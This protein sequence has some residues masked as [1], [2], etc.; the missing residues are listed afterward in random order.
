MV[1]IG[2]TTHSRL[3]P[4]LSTGVAVATRLKDT[5]D[6][7]LH[8]QFVDVLR[9]WSVAGGEGKESFNGPGQQSRRDRKLG[10]EMRILN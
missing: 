6:N 8:T 10:G 5:S 2:Q 4:R 3:I 1:A 7:E 9:C